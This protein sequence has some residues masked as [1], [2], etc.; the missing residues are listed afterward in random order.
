[1]SA[2][3]NLPAEKISE[4]LKVIQTF[5]PPGVGARD[6]RECLMLQ[7][8]RAGQQDSLEY[9]IVRDFMDALGKR[10][11]P[12][13]ARGTGYD[14]RGSAGRARP[15]RAPRTA[16]R[17]RLS[18]GHR[19]IRPARGLRAKGRAMIFRHDQRRAHSAFAHQQHL[20]GSDVAGR[21]HRRGEK[22]HPRKNP[23]RKISHQEPAPAAAD[24]FEHRPRKS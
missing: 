4:V 13:I 8:E 15:H 1:M 21:E 2:S 3:T 19:P 23:R 6:L 5:D 18:A 14:G 22:L 10:R 9:R 12:E 16:A 17:P 20:Q 24:H 11:I 7:L